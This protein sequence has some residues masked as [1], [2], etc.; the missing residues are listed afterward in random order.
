MT[1][2]NEEYIRELKAADPFTGFRLVAANGTTCK[3]QILGRG[4]SVFVQIGSRA[5]I[6]DAIVAKGL[7][8]LKSIR[9]WDD[10]RRITDTER[11]MIIECLRNVFLQKGVNTF[12]LV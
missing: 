6:V 8:A 10:K 7:V 2:A 4:E 9:R 11:E 1:S 5:L 3:L 12:T